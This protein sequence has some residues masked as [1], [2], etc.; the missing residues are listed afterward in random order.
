MFADELKNFNN[1]FDSY[2]EVCREHKSQEENLENEWLNLKENLFDAPK[3][4]IDSIINLLLVLFGSDKVLSDIKVKELI[5][6]RFN[7]DNYFSWLKDYSEN[8]SD[9]VESKQYLY[10]RPDLYCLAY[11]SNLT[12]YDWEDFNISYLNGYSDRAFRIEVYKKIYLGDLDLAINQ[13]EKMPTKYREKEYEN[14]CDAIKKVKEKTE[15][16]ERTG[17]FNDFLKKICRIVKRQNEEYTEFKKAYE[18]MLA[19]LEPFYNFCIDHVIESYKEFDK[20]CETEF[21]PKKERLD[22]EREDLLY[23]NSKEEDNLKNELGAYSVIFPAIQK[24][25][26]SFGE[27]NSSNEYMDILANNLYVNFKDEEYFLN[28]CR[29]LID[30]KNKLDEDEAEKRRQEEERT[31][32][33]AEERKYQKRLDEERFEQRMAMRQQK[34]AADDLCFSCKLKYG[35]SSRGKLNAP[36]CSKYQSSN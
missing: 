17:P 23:T 7:F 11:N 36:V 3:E 18:D 14:L 33:E 13:L 6:E 19:V 25:E 32:K 20:Y 31:R 34:A 30:K 21:K 15:A 27:F 29:D 8:R 12:K 22:Q 2:K 24:L 4:Q 5:N 35:C 1:L 16:L 28:A 10:L 9:Y 26:D